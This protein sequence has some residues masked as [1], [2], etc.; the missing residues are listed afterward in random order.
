[1]ARDDYNNRDQEEWRR[2][3]DR[4]QQLSGSDAYGER[5][6]R[7][8]GQG[9]G[10]YG[11]GGSGRGYGQGYGQ[12]FGQSG[13]GQGPGQGGGYGQGGYGQGGFGQGDYGRSGYGQGGYGQGG[14]EQSGRSQGDYGE[15]SYGQGGFGRGGYRQGGYGQDGSGQGF[16]QGAYGQGI[17]YT[18]AIIIGRFAGRGPKGYRRSDDRI[19]EDVSEELTRHPEIDASDIDVKVENGEVTLTGKV[20][21]RQ[22]KRMAEDLAERCSG[23][24]DVH[25]QLK[26]DKGFFAKLFGG[27]DDDREREKDREQER[28]TSTRRGTAGTSGNR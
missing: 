24:N 16:G 23:V 10:G 11:Q 20:E 17:R 5:G 6:Q 18:S 2:R 28:G 1:M 27:G 13:Y 4:E 15:G 7:E 14:H 21:D 25:N 26:V 3:R 8:G 12:G 19:R 22:Q 9:Q